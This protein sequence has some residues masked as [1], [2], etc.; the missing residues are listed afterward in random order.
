MG[1]FKYVVPAAVSFLLLG[2]AHAG[3]PFVTD[4]PEP[5]EYRHFEINTAA[6]A[7]Y[8]RGGHSGALPTVDVNYGP[9]PDTQVHVGLSAPYA[10]ADG[11]STAVGYG[12][13]EFGLKYRFVAEDEEGWRPQ[14]AIYPNIDLPSG[15]AHEALG[16]GHVRVL[17]PVWA[18]KSVGD[19]T[20]YGGAGYWLNQSG[21]S[22]NYWFM[23]WALLRKFSEEWTLGF[24]LFH[25]TGDLRTE[26]AA[27]GN[28]VSSRSSSGFNFGG[29]YNLDEDDHIMFTFG[30]GLQ[31]VADT[32]RFSYYVG[33]QVVF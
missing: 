29:Y 4:D 9:A 27:S 2:S 6:Q 1:K 17:L 26:P 33:Y 19:W 12:D 7:T 24:E 28:G 11:Q 32:N 31:N 15:N 16:A 8:V 18:Q 5:V 30:K 3:P 14:L 20:T 22:R 21:D 13:T 25:Q 10:A 23:G